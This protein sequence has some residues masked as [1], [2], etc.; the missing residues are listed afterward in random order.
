LGRG[1]GV[2]AEQSSAKCKIRGAKLTLC[3]Y[4]EREWVRGRDG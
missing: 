4:R 3:C 1:Y 2:A